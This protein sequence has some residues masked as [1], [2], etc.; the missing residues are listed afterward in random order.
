[1]RTRRPQQC[2]REQWKE[3]TDQPHLLVV[4]LENLSWTTATS[5]V[6]KLMQDFKMLHKKKERT[7]SDRAFLEKN[8]EYAPSA[9]VIPAMSS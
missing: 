4:E 2:L 1:M 7:G 9:A 8:E 5:Y 3:S 6:F